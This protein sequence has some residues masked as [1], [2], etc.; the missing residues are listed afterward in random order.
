V[1]FPTRDEAAWQQATS[2][3]YVEYDTK[4]NF[5]LQSDAAAIAVDSGRIVVYLTNSA[6]GSQAMVTATKSNTTNIKGIG[7]HESIGYVFPDNLNT[8]EGKGG[9][10]PFIVPLERFK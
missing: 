6:G 3:R 8:T 10:G 5:E 4:V 9:F 1:Q 7:T 2:A